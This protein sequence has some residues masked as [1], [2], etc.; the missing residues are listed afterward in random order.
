MGLRLEKSI[1][2]GFRAAFVL[3][4]AL[5]VAWFS[6][7]LV[8]V[9]GPGT[10]TVA[11]VPWADPAGLAALARASLEAFT[12]EGSPVGRIVALTA[13][14]F[15]M[16]ALAY[17]VVRRY[18]QRR[19]AA[20]ASLREAERFARATVDA[21][22]THIAILNEQGIV[23]DANEAWR[24]F[25]AA[26]A[27][28]RV[29]I[30]ARTPET[31]NYLAVCEEAGGRGCA[32]SAAFAVAIRAVVRGGQNE[33]RIEY[34]AHAE[35]D[36]RWFVAQVT[37]FP[38]GGPVR[39][40]V[41]HDDIT[42]RM[43]A[44]EAMQKAKEDAENA[45]QAK[46]SFLANMSHEIR[47]PMTAIIGYSEMLLDPRQQADDRAKCVGTIRRNSEHLL[48][49]INDILD[50]SKIEAERMSIKRI[51]CYLPQVIADVIALTQTRALKKNLQMRVELDGRAIRAPRADRPAPREAGAGQPRRQRDQVHAGRRSRCGS[52]ARSATSPSRSASTS[53][54][55][56]S[57]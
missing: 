17:R 41:A 48:A 49:L 51:V 22:P 6:H 35:G 32:A 36:R 27:A 4:A 12:N 26:A 18:M 11:P 45:N 2:V 50:I 25:P 42:Q 15:A 46:S 14:D 34:A 16:L 9:A 57:A 7:A 33:F 37:R 40:A 3:M 52:A 21:L 47:T 20:E 13:I 5:R 28:G 23:L 43:L 39:V 54:T 55:P 10:V 38:D 44:E 56:A 19:R 30:A 31:L 1:D 29:G 8:L 53:S 24:R